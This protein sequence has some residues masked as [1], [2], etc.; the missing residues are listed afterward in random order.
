MAGGGARAAVVP[1]AA[2][3]DRDR[4]RLIEAL[5]PAPTEIDALIRFTG[6]SAALVQ[7]LL[8]ELDLAGRI[9]HHAGQRISLLH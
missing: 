7:M 2:Q 4:D 6:L 3:H 1:D 8:L 9:E 5:G